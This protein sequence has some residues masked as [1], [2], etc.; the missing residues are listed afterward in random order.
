MGNNG[1]EWRYANVALIDIKRHLYFVYSIASWG[2]WA[3]GWLRSRVTSCCH[4][5]K[6]VFF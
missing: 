6:W 3:C 2:C 5:Q 1:K 4:Q